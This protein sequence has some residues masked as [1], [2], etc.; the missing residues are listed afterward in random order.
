MTVPRTGLAGYVR[1]LRQVV[2]VGLVG[3]LVMRALW[4]W[5]IWLWAICPR[6]PPARRLR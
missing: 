4:F 5:V 2:S 3:T 1:G 6:S